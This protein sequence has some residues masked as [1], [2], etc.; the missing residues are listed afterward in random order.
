MTDA[1][2]DGARMI[3]A[4][5]SGD[6]PMVRE[7]STPPRFWAKHLKEPAITQALAG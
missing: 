3:A 5:T 6:E 7:P 4:C 2:S 1:N